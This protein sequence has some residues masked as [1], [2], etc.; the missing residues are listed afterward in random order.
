MPQG[1]EE[2]VLVESSLIFAVGPSII[3]QIPKVISLLGKRYVILGLHAREILYNAQS[4]ENG[5][6]KKTITPNV[7]VASI[8]VVINTQLKATTASQDECQSCPHAPK[9]IVCNGLH[10]VDYISCPLKPRYSKAKGALIEAS[11]TE[12]AQIRDQ[13]KVL[14]NRLIRDN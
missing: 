13:Q 11:A 9:C 3:Q 4:V 10:T 12:V 1:V 6:I 7:L 8:V 2:K 14:R 5:V